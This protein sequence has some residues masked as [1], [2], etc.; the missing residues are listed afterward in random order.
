MYYGSDPTLAYLTPAAY[1]NAYTT[2]VYYSGYGYNTAVRCR[3]TCT[4]KACKIVYGVVSG[5]ALLC[6]CL[7]SFIK[8]ACHRKPHTT[9]LAVVAD[10]QHDAHNDI[11]KDDYVN[12]EELANQMAMIHTPAPV[13]EYKGNENLI[14]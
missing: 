12:Q 6:F 1:G 5:I 9:E 7:L 2:S 13:L 3:N 10:L 14:P 11:K 8:I 4:T